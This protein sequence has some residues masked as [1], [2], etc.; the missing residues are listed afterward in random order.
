MSKKIKKAC[1]AL[2]LAAVVG[3]SFS[4]TACSKDSD[5]PEIKISISFNGSNYDIEYK[6]W[7]NM[8][9]QT[10][11]HF[12]ELADAHFYDNTIIHNYSASDWIGGAYSYNDEEAVG[13][14]ASYSRKGM[15]AYLESNCKEEAYHALVKAGYA[16]GSFTPSVFSK[17]IYNDN[18]EEI[19]SNDDALTTLIG[20]FAT[21]GH[22][23]VDNKGL[24]A[25]LGSLKMVYYEKEQQSVTVKN[26]FG[27]ILPRDYAYNCATSLFSMQMSSSTAYSASNYCIFGQLKND[28]ARE[29]LDDLKEAVS[30]YSASV[31]SSSAFTTSVVTTVDK[32]DNFA[33]EGGKDIEKTFTVISM[34]IIITRIS[35]VKY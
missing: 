22:R 23:I 6:L 21:N 14:S 31:G 2:A 8:Y 25:N 17:S 3:A 10:V 27:Q 7:R 18:G 19:V 1:L 15:A 30:D 33:E 35:V 11:Q 26:S 28:D 24:N 32:E 34:P 16:N 20:E 12:I 5:H 13:Y 9:P 29:V 4:A